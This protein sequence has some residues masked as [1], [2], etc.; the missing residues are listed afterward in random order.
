[1]H[2]NGARADGIY[3]TWTDCRTCDNCG[4]NLTDNAMIRTGSGDE[5][6]MPCAQSMGAV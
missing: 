2:G 6:C 4:D 5:L 3:S 1:M